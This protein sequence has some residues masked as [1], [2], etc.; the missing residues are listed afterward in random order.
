MRATAKF[1]KRSTMQEVLESYPSAQRALFQR[2]PVHGRAT[3]RPF[4]SVVSQARA[5]RSRR[6]R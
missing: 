3:L 1:T 5:A 4:R 2:D 6:D